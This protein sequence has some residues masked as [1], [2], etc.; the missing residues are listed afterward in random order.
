MC[1]WIIK[2]NQFIPQIVFAVKVMLTRD[3]IMNH[4]FSFRGLGGFK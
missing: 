1:D 4:M 2:N 3:G